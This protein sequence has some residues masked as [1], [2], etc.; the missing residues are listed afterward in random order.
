MWKGWFLVHNYFTLFS[1]TSSVLHRI[2]KIP[3]VAF[4][5]RSAWHREKRMSHCNISILPSSLESILISMISHFYHR[6][7]SKNNWDCTDVF[8]KG[9]SVQPQTFLF[10]KYKKI[11]KKAVTKRLGRSSFEIV[12]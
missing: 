2:T 3:A 4:A 9:K 1:C 7:I 10:L 6:I 11:V 5:D 8:N 12:Q